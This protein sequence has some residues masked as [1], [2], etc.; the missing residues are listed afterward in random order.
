[1]ETKEDYDN[2]EVTW[3]V[4][5]IPKYKITNLQNYNYKTIVIAIEKKKCIQSR[6]VGATSSHA[7]SKVTKLQYNIV[8]P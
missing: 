6:L 8:L 4:L 7:E 3:E 1:M 2:W 5:A